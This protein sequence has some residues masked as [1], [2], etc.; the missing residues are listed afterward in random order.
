M[1]TGMDTLNENFIKIT[2]HH[3]TSGLDYELKVSADSSWSTLITQFILFLKGA[4]YVVTEEDIIE[5]LIDYTGYELNK[6]ND[7]FDW[8]V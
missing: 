8:P 7:V 6:S 3:Q 5:Y 4:G 2:L 1:D